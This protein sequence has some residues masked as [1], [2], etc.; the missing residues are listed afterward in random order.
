MKH[1]LYLGAGVLLA[2]AATSCV[3]DDYD[4]SDIDSTVRV[5]V[6]DLTVPVNI[7][8]FTM[9]SIFDIDP[10]DPDATVQVVDGVYA[11][12]REGDFTTD[13][14]KIGSLRLAADD[15]ESAGT[16]LETGVSGQVPGGIDIT[17]P[18]HTEEVSVSSE[19]D[20]VPV[21]ITEIDKIGATFTI[22]ASSG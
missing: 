20:A 15:F 8:P 19:S 21:E 16:V 7:D 13:E 5:Q 22:N 3:D 18:F 6:N 11:I 14:I 2:A 1:F 4:L 12:V 10:N 9:E 17:V